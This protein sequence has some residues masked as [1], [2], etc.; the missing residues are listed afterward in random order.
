MSKRYISG[1]NLMGYYFDL[2]SVTYRLIEAMR[3]GVLN[4]GV[5][6][7]REDTLRA[8]KREIVGAMTRLDKSAYPFARD[9]GYHVFDGQPR[10]MI[11][12]VEGHF[13]YKNEQTLESMIGVDLG[14]NPW[15]VFQ[16]GNP[17]ETI[18]SMAT[19]YAVRQ[20]F[21]A[22][23][24]EL[25][26]I[27]GFDV[28]KSHFLYLG[29]KAAAKLPRDERGEIDMSQLIPLIKYTR[30]VG[31]TPVSVPSSAEYSEMLPV[32]LTSY[33]LKASL[34]DKLVD[35]LGL[36][37]ISRDDVIRDWA[38]HRVVVEDERHARDLAQFLS[39]SPTIGSNGTSRIECIEYEDGYKLPEDSGFKTLKIT[40]RVTVTEGRPITTIR[41][42]HILDR[43]EYY[44]SEIRPKGPANRLQFERKREQRIR[45]SGATNQSLID[46]QEVLGKLFGKPTGLVEVV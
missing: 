27:R 29:D 3:D 17:H 7:F 10:R 26:G 42:I 23:R 31:F 41:R 38:G 46:A 24:E 2:D 35:R 13:V 39:G 12:I 25:E 15:Q 19:R 11:A 40:A 28:A 34:T 37:R 36:P 30:R 22:H 21:A 18:D 4:G 43:G 16:D 33:R 5:P 20:F 14:T 8:A 44:K 9:K 32:P 45:S 6:R 1:L